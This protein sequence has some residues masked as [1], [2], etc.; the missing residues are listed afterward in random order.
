LGSFFVT[1]RLIDAADVV[2]EARRSRRVVITFDAAVC[3]AGLIGNLQCGIPYHGRYTPAKNTWVVTGRMGDQPYDTTSPPYDNAPDG[4][5]NISVFGV[6][7][8]FDREG[9]LSLRGVENAGTVVPSR[10][11]WQRA[12]F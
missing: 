7:G 11:L 1:L 9:K 3:R 10:S 5:G 4:P 2:D 12:F 8:K 6:V